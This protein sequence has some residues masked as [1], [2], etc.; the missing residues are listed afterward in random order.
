MKCTS[1]APAN[2]TFYN[3]GL[4]L[5]DKIPHEGQWVHWGTYSRNSRTIKVWHKEWGQLPMLELAKI[6]LHFSVSHVC[7]S[8]FYLCAR[9]TGHP[10]C[11]RF[12][13]K[14]L[15]SCIGLLG[16][17]GAYQSFHHW[18]HSISKLGLRF[19]ILHAMKKA[20]I[21]SICE[22]QSEPGP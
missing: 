20:N 18:T 5:A 9:G 12:L 7:F 15:P 13:W 14:M 1:L 3:A 10:A 22:V 2:L 11:F 17:K 19:V 6:L 21:N 16:L 8:G 4:V